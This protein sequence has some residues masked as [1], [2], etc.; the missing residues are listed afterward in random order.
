MFF[1][2]NLVGSHAS[3]PSVHL[4]SA[5]PLGRLSACRASSYWSISSSL[6]SC[7]Q[8]Q[9]FREGLHLLCEPSASRLVCFPSLLG[10]LRVS[11]RTRQM[12]EMA[13]NCWGQWELNNQ[14]VWILEHMQV[15]FD[16]SV[17]GE[18][19]PQPETLPRPT[20][21]FRGGIAL[22]IF[23]RGRSCSTR[24]RGKTPGHMILPPGCGRQTAT[25]VPMSVM[26][27]CRISP[28]ASAPVR[29]RS[30]SG[31]RTRCSSL[32]RTCFRVRVGAGC[33]NPTRWPLQ[34][35]VYADVTVFNCLHLL[36]QVTRITGR[37]VHG[38]P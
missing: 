13:I 33:L 27:G 18:T 2:T 14:P 30:G 7:C 23:G 9:S 20:I 10:R 11:R 24:V 28:Q 1:F 4:L 35:N 26:V 37:W 38:S 17:T 29:P 12:S 22:A 32:A 15:A 6:S 8:H 36:L 16:S 19:R 5:C 34:H 25:L 31:S 21:L 3:C